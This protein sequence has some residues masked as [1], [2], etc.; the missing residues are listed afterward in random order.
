MTP[1]QKIIDHKIIAI[2]R[3]DDYSR[4]VEVAR[5]LVAGGVPVL[6][7]T[8]TGKGAIEAVAATRRA[9]GEAVCAGVGSVLQ[10]EDAQAAID[11]GAQ[12]VVT[13]AV[14]LA[15]IAACIN[16]NTPIVCGGF[17]PTE[18]LEA[19]EAGS[20][21]VKLFPAQQGGPRYL[22]DALAPMPFHK[23]VPTG[24]VRAENARDYLAAGAVAVGIGGNLVS[25]QAVATG[26]FEQITAAARA[27]VAAIG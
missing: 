16:R 27:C 14:R 21:L 3:L 23:L 6:E 5:A 15:V 10:A 8:L 26:A 17:T 1:T 24:G 12:F 11:S 20:E 25:K 18:L 2:I 22:K 4:A 7:F 19:H 9:L 13:P